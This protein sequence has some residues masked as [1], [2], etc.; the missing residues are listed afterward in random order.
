MSV[1]KI[2]H[3]LI[4]I[5]IVIVLSSVLMMA[6]RGSLPG[7]GFVSFN[8][9]NFR[10]GSSGI[11]WFDDDDE[12]RG[13][14]MAN[15]IDNQYSLSGIRNVELKF[16]SQSIA[17]HLTDEDKI[18]IVQESN[19]SLLPEDEYKVKTDGDTFTAY[20]DWKDNVFNL[21]N[22]FNWGHRNSRITAYIPKRY[23]GNLRVSS[24]SGS[25]NVD[26]GLN[27]GDV[28]VSST[29][30]SVKVGKIRC[31]SYE[32]TS[33]SGSVTAD[34]I[35]SNATSRNKVSS[36]SGSVK[37]YIMGNDSGEV[38]LGSVSGSV[39]A[40][41]DGGSVKASST[42]GSVK[43]DVKRPQP[44]NYIEGTSVSGSVY[45]AL[46]GAMQIKINASTVS[47]SIHVLGDHYKRNAN[48]NASGD[49]AEV[50]ASTVSGNINIE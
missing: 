10:I 13:E 19:E 1:S 17:V 37:A 6:I 23:E 47:G 18:R 45:I 40:T 50:K 21:F 14:N 7:G 16:Y 2:I 29:S 9:G 38:V 27:I 3:L 36:T 49:V 48:V 43:L 8:I 34:H 24:V 28:R 4:L 20:V 11:G 15:S 39:N 44:N 22:L 35:V 42:S 31:G 33:T 5:F 32:I 46:N 26:E 30:G 41:V 12:M 25:V